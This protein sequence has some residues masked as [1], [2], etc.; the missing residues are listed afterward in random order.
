MFRGLRHRI[1]LFSIPKREGEVKHRQNT[2][3][4]EMKRRVPRFLGRCRKTLANQDFLMTKKKVPAI[5]NFSS[6]S[7]TH[8]HTHTPLSISPLSPYKCLSSES[9]FNIYTTYTLD[10]GHFLP[11][12]SKFPCVQYKKQANNNNRQIQ[13]FPE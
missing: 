5:V 9:L 13:T 3:P 11:R 4:A 1:P 10:L 12:S 2:S 8:S 7:Q 6:C